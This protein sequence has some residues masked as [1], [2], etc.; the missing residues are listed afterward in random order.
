MAVKR[1]IL[2]Y[3]GGK[4]KLAS[5]IIGFFSPHR[6]Y[7]EVYGG[8]GSVL[9]RKE[10]SHT[11]VYN[12]LDAE[13]VN[14]FRVLR[15]DEKAAELIRLLTLT[16]YSRDE[17]MSSYQIEGD[18]IARAWATVVRSFMG[19][20]NV[21]VTS[22]SGF[23]SGSRL[24]GASAASDW[25]RLPQSLEAIVERL[26]GVMIENRPA[27]DVLNRYDSQ[28]TLHYVDPPYVRSTRSGRGTGGKVYRHEMTDDDHKDLASILHGLSGMVV[29]SGYSSPLYDDLYGDWECVSQSTRADSGGERIEVLW[30]NPPAVQRPGLLM[31]QNI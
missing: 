26:R 7:T 18:C 15:D 16:P 27:V 22:K 5:W 19:Y 17:Y 20:G 23:R 25:A 21:A 31:G 11:E 29:L 3:H 13:V 12:D 10:R 6:V 1:P 14:V 4:W 30:L 8:G 2:R 9:L 28:A 24:S